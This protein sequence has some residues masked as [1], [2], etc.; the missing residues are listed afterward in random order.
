MQHKDSTEMI[1]DLLRLSSVFLILMFL[2]WWFASIGTPWP[3]PR[4]YFPI[5][6]V[7]FLICAIWPRHHL[8]SKV[9]LKISRFFAAGAI[10]ACIP[11][12]VFDR[13]TACPW[14]QHTCGPDW[15]DVVLELIVAS[16][17]CV[18]LF[19]GSRPVETASNA[20]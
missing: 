18:Y 14:P 10:I 6:I 20:A 13:N 15:F 5:N 11:K 3:V 1:V 2:F 12:I 9:F 16:L 17:F 4:I 7:A 19:E 8:A